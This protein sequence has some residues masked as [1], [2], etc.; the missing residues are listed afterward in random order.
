[1]PT[2]TLKA[3]GRNSRWMDERAGRAVAEAFG[4]KVTGT[5]AVIGMAKT[6]GWIASAHETFARLHA[7]EFRVAAAVVNEVLRRVGE[8]T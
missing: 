8:T 6:R 7:A 3:T 4:L 5:A 2:P 1:M